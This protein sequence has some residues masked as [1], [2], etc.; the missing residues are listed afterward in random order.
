MWLPGTVLGA[1][2]LLLAG[3]AA[4]VHCAVM[5]GALGVHHLR[6]SAGLPAPVALAWLHL[7]RVLGYGTLGALSGALGQSLL[8]LLPDPRAGAVLQIVAD[9]ALIGVGVQLL[10]AHRRRPAAC[11]PAPSQGRVP[12][13]PG[14]LNL[15]IRGLLWAV[16]PCG[17]LY[18]VLLLAALSGSAVDGG[19]LAAA[20]ALG[21]APLLAT[22]AWRGARNT[23]APRY[24]LAG[25][26]LIGI[27]LV[28]LAAILVLPHTGVPGWCTTGAGA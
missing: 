25:W 27:G 24:Q 18:S 6:A 13:L 2:A 10:L 23:S 1:P 16:L 12:G 17:L 14:W 21:G 20:F 19:L 5:C 4:G 9:A 22:V 8:R 15:L 28:G 11:C 3:T 26:W 7:G